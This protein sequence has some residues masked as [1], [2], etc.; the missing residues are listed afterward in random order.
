MGREPTEEEIKFTLSM[1][2]YQLKIRG[3]DLKTYNPQYLREKAEKICRDFIRDYPDELM[4]KKLE[5]QNGTP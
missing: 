4:F 1:I 5:G 3:D 2:R